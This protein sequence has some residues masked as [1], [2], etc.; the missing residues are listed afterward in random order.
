M[1]YSIPDSVLEEIKGRVDL[2]D[3]ISS[4]GIQVRRAGADYKA[5]CPFHHEKTPSFV[6]HPDRGFYHCFGCGESGNVFK[7]VQKQ[8]GLTFIEAVKKLAERCGVTIEE[9]EDPQAGMRKRL[10]AMH[11]ELAAFYRRCLLQIKEAQPARDYLKSRALD[12]DIAERFQI[13]YAPI[14]SRA[15]LTWAAKN[16]FRPEDLQ[17]A[18]VL[19]P[20]RFPGGNWYNRFAG[21]VVFP[22]R[23]KSGRTV[24]FSCRTLETDKAKMRGGKYV[25][26]PETVLFKKSDILYALDQAAGNIVKAP[27]REAIVCEGQI[28]V[29]RCHACGFNVAVASQGTSF[30]KEQVQI[31]RRCAD[32]VVLV[33]D[34]D[35]A[36][37]KA[38]L[39]TGGEFLAAGIPVRVATLPEGEDPDSLLRTKGPEAFQACLDAAE[40]IT[41][42]QVRVL[43]AKEAHPDSI[44]AFTRVSRAVLETI[45]LCTSAVMRASLL[46]E[47]ARLLGVPVSAL[48]EDLAKVKANA[49]RSSV[50]SAAP[51]KAPVPKPKATSAPAVAP[52]PNAAAVRNVSSA[53]VPA[54]FS[55]IPDEILYGPDYADA[56]TEDD[57]HDAAAPV[58]NPPPPRET[59]LCEFLFVHERDADLAEMLRACAPMEVFAHDFTRAF[60]TAWLKE[61]ES[62]ADEIADLRRALPPEE[63]RWLDRILIAA[64]RGGLTEL[65]P[66]RILEDLLR[67]IWQ[68]AIRRLQGR[69]DVTSSEENDRRR[70]SYSVL[71]RKFQRGRWD[72]I[73]PLMVVG[74]LY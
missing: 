16:D 54:D 63:C 65:A 59:A 9:K 51:A 29:I 6:I 12:G 19:L 64:D 3:L 72:A 22:I 24:A 41:A 60:V 10:L 25:N 31:L 34:A 58:N 17:A 61:L 20:P 32:S 36:G 43:R 11:A 74:S 69:L 70:L 53:S 13:G 48:E 73:R 44:D 37:Q 55:D 8:E 50:S 68:A 47:V 30:T 38:A 46:A 21:R 7:F 42:F 35:G 40:S 5:C 14:S 33:F 23:D 26:S 57:A 66:S 52:V 39:R 18:G 71:A 62:S 67:Q 45:A 28:D 2:A 15:M 49:P 1:A 4:Y 27:R 56:A